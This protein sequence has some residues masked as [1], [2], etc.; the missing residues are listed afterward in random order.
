MKLLPLLG[1][2]DVRF[3]AESGDMMTALG[4][5]LRRREHSSP[6]YPTSLQY[7]AFTLGFNKD[8]RLDF[9]AV[10]KE[11]GRVELWGEDPFEIAAQ[12]SDAYEGI[13]EWLRRS[14]REA[15]PHQDSFGVT[16]RVPGEGVTFCFEGPD[17]LALAG[18]QLC[19]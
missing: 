9:I 17:A 8:E 12:A 4:E 2:D 18:I 10:S 14:G 1:F 7:G 6:E 5:P 3:G 19:P 13:T 16:I 15:D 11:A